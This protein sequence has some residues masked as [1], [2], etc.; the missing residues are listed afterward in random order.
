MST[1]Q[2]E[3]TQLQKALSAIKES[4]MIPGTSHFHYPVAKAAKDF[5][6]S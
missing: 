3:E 4:K 6:V 5:G 2:N 1:I